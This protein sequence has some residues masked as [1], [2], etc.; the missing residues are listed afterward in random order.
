MRII[1]IPHPL[2]LRIRRECFVCGAIFV[3]SD[4]TY[5]AYDVGGDLMGDLCESCVADGEAGLRAALRAQAA[6]RRERA[7]WFEDLAASWY[8]WR[9]G[10]AEPVSRRLSHRKEGD[11][12]C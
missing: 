12:P 5:V 8:A 6:T 7:L 10:Q 11:P 9:E 4:V 1:R 3:L 2:R